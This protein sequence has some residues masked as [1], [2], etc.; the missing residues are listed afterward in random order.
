[1][2][3]PLQTFLSAIPIYK[4]GLIFLLV[5]I[6]GPFITMLVGWV[7]FLGYLNPL[8]AY[9]MVV[10]A[11]LIS[12]CIYFGIGWWGRNKKISKLNTYIKASSGRLQK[13][14]ALLHR[15]SGKTIII[16]KLT[17][18]AGVPFLIAAG[19]ARIR[20]SKFL[21]YDFIA[22]IPKSLAFILLGYYFGLATSQV[23]HYLEYSTIVASLCIAVLLLVYLRL[24]K[25]VDK[26]FAEEASEK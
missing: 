4:Y 23:N 13:I 15:H 16:A 11:D 5:M 8:L 6:E 7:I 14:E 19:L 25:Y 21:A 2:T 20:F 17:H 1:M 3:I 12:D 22:T 18:V 24:G 9:G 26:K 10:C